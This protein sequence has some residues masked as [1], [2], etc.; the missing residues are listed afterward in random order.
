MGAIWR[1]GI[2]CLAR[3]VRCLSRIA[4]HEPASKAGT[5]GFDFRY[6]RVFQGYS[7]MRHCEV[8]V[9]LLNVIKAAEQPGRSYAVYMRCIIRA[10]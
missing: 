2:S 5:F 3:L 10:P 1:I 9:P 8:K 6:G 7:R 4:V